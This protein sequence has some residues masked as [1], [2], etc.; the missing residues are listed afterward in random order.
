MSKNVSSAAVVVGALRVKLELHGINS[1]GGI[2]RYVYVRY[3][4]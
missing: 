3:G 4:N 2:L 1:C